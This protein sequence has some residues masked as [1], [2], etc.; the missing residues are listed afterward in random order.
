[1]NKLATITLAALVASG[2]AAIARPVT[3]SFDGL[4]DTITITPNKALVLYATVHLAGCPGARLHHPQS[5]P[6]PGI[7]IVVK[8]NPGT[9]NARDLAITDTLPDDLGAPV[10]YMYKLDYPL[11]TGGGWIAYSTSDG[12]VLSKG[13]SGT[14]TLH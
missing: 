4:C 11:V 8:K 10:A 9:T 3:V 2:S 14:Y 1:M 5:N 12:K 13:A 7:G 6:I